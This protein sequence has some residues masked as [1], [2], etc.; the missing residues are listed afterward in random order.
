MPVF[1]YT[2]LDANGKEFK[3]EI[4]A[5]NSKEAGSKIRNQ[6][7]YPTKVKAKGGAKKVK[8]DTSRRRGR[9]GV[10]KK[11]GTKAVT[12][13]ARQLSTLQDAGLS[14]LRS[15][16][17]LEEQQK[18]GKPLKKIIAAM[19]E[20]IEGGLSLSESMAKYNK[21][22]DTLFVNMIAAGELGGVLDVI[23]N[24]VADFYESAEKLKSR[25]KSALTYPTVVLAIA[26]IILLGLMKFIVPQ[27]AE[28][29]VDM[30][31][32]KAELPAITLAL[33]DLSDWI[34]NQYGWVYVVAF[35]IAFKIFLKFVRKFRYGRLIL[36]KIK[37]RLP[38]VGVLS[39][40][41]CVA[42][43][44]RTLGTLISAGVPILDAI[45]I[46]RDTA[47]NEVYA[48]VLDKVHVAIRQG[49]TFAN[50]LRKTKAVDPLVVN[51]IDVGEETGDLDKMLYK[52]A[53]NFD[54]DVDVL[55][56]SLMSLIE[57]LMI[58][59]L[60]LIV[61]TIVLAMFLPI[62]TIITALMG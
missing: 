59:G 48:G 27:F 61:G 57:P 26:I 5:L 19:S 45:N 9:F 14:V 12:Q 37:L 52:V 54:E 33:M 2:A 7:N 3:A 46:T 43:W 36:D 55:V 39:Y 38:V 47:N 50:P 1:E 13:F 16:Q 25:V 32:G 42:R 8:V 4:E 29:L 56:G 20:D 31:D 24:R 28:V 10:N 41:I 11:V 17:I 51:M 44:T 22:F 15:L 53:D 23:L 18:K 30:T 6:G 35:P 40:K 60:G 58:V 34:S 21:C 49:D 62:V